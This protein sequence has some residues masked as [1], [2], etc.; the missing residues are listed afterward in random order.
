MNE[1]NAREVYADI[2][3]LPHHQSK[4]RPHMSLYDR[5]A[6]FSPFA[7][8]TG[9]D[10]MVRE[11]ARLTDQKI[12]LGE[13]DLDLLNQKMNLITE[14]IEEGRNPEITAIF[15]VP[16]ERKDGGR[17]QDYTGTVKKV[18]SIAQELVF[19]ASNGKTDGFK[20]E[21]SQ[22]IEIY[23]EMLDSVIHDHINC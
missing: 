9:Y 8:L 13:Q 7:A 18:D 1:K 23:G 11:E 10:D 15:F 5:A 19:F 16:D 22:M 6:Q 2:I 3:D 4:T 21:F 14:L 12:E 17:Y 20:I